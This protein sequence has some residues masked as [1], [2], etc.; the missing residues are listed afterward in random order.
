MY[1]RKCGEK[2]L[3]TDNF[4]PK[5]GV[6]IVVSNDNSTIIKMEDNKT[7]EI[8]MNWYKIFSYFCLPLIFFVYTI[9]L[10]FYN[11]N[12]FSYDKIEF[13]V[14]LINI[15]EVFL[16]GITICSLFKKSIH[17]FK[18]IVATLVVNCLNFAG[19]TSIQF[20]NSSL[21]FWI[22]L[23]LFI[24]IWF[25]PNYVYFNKRKNIFIN[26]DK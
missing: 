10:F 22:F 13:G 15:A 8:S 19:T 24:L 6:K 16:Y 21:Y 25:I 20:K 3:D 14:F 7:K 23:I 26:K 12:S 5:C 11:F 17:T 9:T 1:C 2:L 4:C 18:Y